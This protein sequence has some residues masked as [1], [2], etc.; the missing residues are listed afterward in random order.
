MTR[1][2]NLVMSL[3]L[4]ALAGCV[5]VPVRGDFHRQAVVV[6]QVPSAANRPAS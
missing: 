2:L 1:L 3:G 5:V 4:V 6:V